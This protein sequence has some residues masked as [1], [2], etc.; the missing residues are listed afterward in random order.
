MRLYV[1][2]EISVALFVLG[3]CQKCCSVCSG[4]SSERHSS[5]GLAELLAEKRCEEFVIAESAGDD[6]GILYLF[7]LYKSSDLECDRVDDAGSKVFTA[8]A[9]THVV[10]DFGFCKYCTE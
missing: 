10:Y 7:P 2:S 6:D 8:S 9:F 1:I 5:N 3:F 4:I